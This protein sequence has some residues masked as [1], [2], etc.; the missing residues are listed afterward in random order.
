MYSLSPIVPLD[1]LRGARTL[2]PGRLRGKYEVVNERTGNVP[3]NA[4][5]TAR[6]PEYHP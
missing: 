1:L 3:L 5:L 2:T 4:F 6:Q